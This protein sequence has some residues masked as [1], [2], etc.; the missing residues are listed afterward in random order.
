MNT[1][2]I[3][4][5]RSPVLGNPGQ[6]WAFTLIELLVV[7]AIIA[8]LAA[9]L[10]PALSRAKYK[11]MRTYCINNIHQQYIS[12]IMYADDNGGKFCFHYDQFPDE[13]RFLPYDAGK[14][15]VDLMRQTYVPN[16]AVLIC[17][18]TKKEFGPIYLNFASMTNYEAS[19]DTE[20][21]GWDTPAPVVWTPYMWLANF[22]PIAATAAPGGTW[23]TG[24]ITYVDP[25]GLANANPALN[26]PAW[27]ARTSECD[28]R[29]AFITHRL[30]WGWAASFLDFGHGGRGFVSPPSASP[31]PVSL[32]D[33]RW[34]TT[35]EQPV[36]RADG[37]V[38]VH[39]KALLIPRATFPIG[40]DEE[41]FYY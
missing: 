15:I 2:G 4:N 16:T 7:I 33:L 3:V 31:I 41:T 34:S 19:G 14:N 26:E 37:S 40:S 27:P 24:V 9:L 17:P 11:S 38:I 29:R 25:S 36:G 18:I 5:Q 32:R 20:T 10:L 30:K 35:V 22:T 1:N 39:K 21:G 12:Q 13:Q 8:I 28:S 6:R 23:E